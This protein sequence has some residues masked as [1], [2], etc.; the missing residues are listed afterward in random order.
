MKIPSDIEVYGDMSYRGKCATESAEQATFFNQLTP[1]L[2]RLAIHP[3]NEGKRTHA[4]VARD[5]AQG[6]NTGASDIIIVGAPTFVCELKRRDHNKS[7]ITQQQVDFLLNAQ[8]AGAF[9]CIA[10]GYEAAM[11]ALDKWL[12]FQFD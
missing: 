2:R 3:K 4:Q 8:A 10:L 7:T 6:L 1:N 12:L 5:K 11:L 9:A